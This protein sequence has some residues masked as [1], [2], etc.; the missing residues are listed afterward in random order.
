MTNPKLVTILDTANKLLENAHG[1][2][3]MQSYMLYDV[4]KKFAI[5]TVLH[6]Q[7]QFGV[8]F[9]YLREK[10]TRNYREIHMVKLD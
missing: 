3:L 8:C 1:C 7:K 10:V 6:Y 5:L 4:V 9:Y 2:L